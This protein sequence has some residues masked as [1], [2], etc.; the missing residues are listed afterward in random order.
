[1]DAGRQLNQCVYKMPPQAI[2]QFSRAQ[3]EYLD[4]VDFSTLSAFK[5]CSVV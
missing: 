3:I 5:H 2:P 1:M 4:D